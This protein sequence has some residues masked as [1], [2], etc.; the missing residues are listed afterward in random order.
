MW[1]KFQQRFTVRKVKS[2]G[3]FI[4]LFHSSSSLAIDLPALSACHVTTTAAITSTTTATTTSTISSTTTTSTTAIT[5]VY[6]YW[7]GKGTDVDVGQP[8]CLCSPSF[9][10]VSR[11]AVSASF[12]PLI[13]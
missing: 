1:G 4:D 7:L 10:A 11:S 6:N 5:V 9:N 2:P 3:S 12:L 8:Q 13:T